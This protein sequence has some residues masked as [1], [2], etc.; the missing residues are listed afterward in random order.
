VV[1]RGLKAQAD[2]TSP[3]PGHARPA[4][5]AGHAAGLEVENAAQR[6]Q[7]LPAATA[8]KSCDAVYGSAAAAYG[9]TGVDIACD[10]EGVAHPNPNVG[11]LAELAAVSEPVA[12]KIVHERGGR[13][14]EQAVAK[15]RHQG[16]FE[17]VQRQLV[18]ASRKMEQLGAQ[19]GFGRI[20]ALRY[21]HT[22]FTRSAKQFGS[23]ISETTMRPNP[24]RR[25]SRCGCRW[26]PS[27]SQRR[28]RQA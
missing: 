1:S 16:G 4:G 10:S 14:A 9:P 19:V 12:Q 8:S 26:R 5:H 27:A 3:H 23:S 17:A 25:S 13:A 21:R 28:S 6:V 2:P 22:L 15:A 24:L 7:V 20:T 11:Q 18:A